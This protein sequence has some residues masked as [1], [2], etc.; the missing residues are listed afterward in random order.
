MRIG[1]LLFLLT[2]VAG[3]AIGPDYH[4]PPIVPPPAWR[5]EE[6]EVRNVIDTEWWRQFQDPVLDDLIVTAIRGNKDL[7]AATAR[8]EEVYGQYGAVR[9]GL[10]PQIGYDASAQRQRTTENGFVPIEPGISPVYTTYRPEFTASWEIDIWGRL[11]R[12]TEAARADLLGSEEARQGV[13]L[14]V[15]TSVAAAYI[16]LRSLDRQ[17]EIAQQ[18][19]KSYRQTLDL[20]R[21]SFRHGNI[22]EVELSQAESQYYGAL[23]SIPLLQ[24]QIAQQENALSLLLG[25]DPGPVPRGKAIDRLNL[26][27]I[28]AGLPSDLLARRPDIRQAEQVLISANAQIGVAKG[29]YFPSISLTGLLGTSSTELSSLFTGPSQVWSYSGTVAGPIFTGG[30]IKNQIRT[31]EAVKREMVAN[32]ERTIQNGF[33][34]VNDALAD[35]DRTRRRRDALANQVGA[36]T[37]YAR[38]ARLRFDNGYAA[39]LEVLDAQSRLFVS[40]LSYTQTLGNLFQ[41]VINVYKAMGGGWVVKADAMGNGQVS[42][43]SGPLDPRPGGR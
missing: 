38:L 25:H 13:V 15:V 19:A 29:Q 10:F 28:P 12:A 36:L 23:A 9:A 18:T 42:P 37:T 40:E 32:Y 24:K 26:P 35:Q 8:V 6:T 30:R 39:Y 3:C 2:A 41:A 33:R 14:T 16:T 4:R 22:S 20:F 43:A 21:L 34:D 17:L 7:L 31:A 5:V 11:R 27:S 1:I